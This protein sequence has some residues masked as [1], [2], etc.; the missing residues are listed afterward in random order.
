MIHPD[1]TQMLESCI[2]V[3]QCSHLALAPDTNVPWMARP[4]ATPVS[5]GSQAHLLQAATHNLWYRLT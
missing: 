1:Y 5:V 2:F 4:G 3:A